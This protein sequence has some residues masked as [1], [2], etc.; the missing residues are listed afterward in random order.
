MDELAD[1]RARKK[2]GL[3]HSGFHYL[4]RARLD[5]FVIVFVGADQVSAV[6]LLARRIEIDTDEIREHFLA[7]HLSE[8]LAFGDVFLPMTFH[9]M[10]EDLMKEDSRG[11]AGKNG[12]AD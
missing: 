12:R 9:A 7:E 10:A 5:A 6:V 1:R 11:A 8:G 4:D 3:E 2:K